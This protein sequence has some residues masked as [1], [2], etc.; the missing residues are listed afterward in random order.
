MP[1]IPNWPTAF[2]TAILIVAGMFAIRGSVRFD[3]NEYLRDRK[4]SFQEKA[5]RACPH[6]YLIRSDDG[7]IE[8]QKAY[9]IPPRTTVW[10]CARCGATTI[11]AFDW[12]K[13]VN[14]YR[15]HPGEFEK[16]ERKFMK[17]G[18]KAL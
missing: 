6:S 4:K 16:A 12:E 5:K 18:K 3:I 8:I 1:E 13:N 11:S 14:Y 17:I 15:R 2:V 7:T 10:T 9:H